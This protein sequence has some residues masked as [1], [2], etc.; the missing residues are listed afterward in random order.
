MRKITGRVLHNR[1]GEMHGVQYGLVTL[2]TEDGLHVEVRYDLQVAGGVLEPGSRVEMDVEGESI[3]RAVNIIILAKPM[4]VYQRQLTP[5]QK[6]NVNKSEKEK[7]Y[8]TLA[9]VFAF[10]TWASSYWGTI[11]GMLLFF[12]GFM[13]CICLV[14]KERSS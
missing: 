10:L 12:C 8:S 2:E 1:T 3:L 11:G 5:K 7:T 6:K 4:P 9:T 14:C 13:V